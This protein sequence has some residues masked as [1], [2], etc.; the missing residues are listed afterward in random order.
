MGD[1]NCLVENKIIK[2]VSFP[3]QHALLTCFVSF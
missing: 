3:N 1:D 2:D